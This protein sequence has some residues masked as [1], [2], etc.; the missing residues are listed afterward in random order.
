M[1]ALT[2]D[3]DNEKNEPWFVN[4]NKRQCNYSLITVHKIYTSF[5]I[6]TLCL[7]TVADG[8]YLKA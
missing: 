5:P 6:Q 8:L 2:F 4:V 3:L 7:H 1:L